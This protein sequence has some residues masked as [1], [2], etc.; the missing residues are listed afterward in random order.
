MNKKLNAKAV[1]PLPVTGKRYRVWDTDIKGFNV[2][3][4]PKGKKTYIFTYRTQGT[5]KEFTLGIHGNITADE[6]RDLAKKQAGKVADRTDI[7]AE[8]KELKKQAKLAKS[9]ALVDFIKN[10][11]LPWAESHLK[12]WKLSKE[13]IERDFSHLLNRTVSDISKWDVQKW[14]AQASKS[15]LKASTINR[16][17]A[18]LKGVVS[19]AHEWN[20]IN[21]NPLRG[22]KNLKTDNKAR[23][24]YLSLKE[25]KELRAELESRQEKHRKE[26][27][28][29]IEWSKERKKTPPPLP[30][31]KFTDHLMPMVLLSLN[32][33]MR[34][35]EL[36]NLQWRDIDLKGRT[37]TIEG[38]TAKSGETRHIP[39][40]DEALA[41]LIAWRNQ[42]KS[43][44]LVFP[45]P[46][47]GDT[48]NNIST[49][50]KK[51]ISDSGVTNFRFHDLRHHFASQLVMAGVDINTVRELLGHQDIATTLR[52][53]HLAPE[54]KAAAVAML[55]KGVQ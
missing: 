15:G 53:A 27:L 13:V 38:T 41:T 45:S 29:F 55:N 31:D 47:T 44:I 10:E 21:S 34:R 33:G 37:A 23:V 4:S 51:L 49:A 50:W 42:T 5:Q 28:Q 48:F 8:E 30:N 39:L 6:A 46:K 35:G 19:K 54:H 17:T 22:M 16:R 11:Y 14:S 3:V 52:Y 2:R 1:N 9:S 7:R 20:F 40:N 43:K 12:S 25:E 24:R 36:F 32:T 18:I 26:R